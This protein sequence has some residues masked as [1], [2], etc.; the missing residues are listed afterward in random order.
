MPTRANTSPPTRCGRD[1][2]GNHHQARQFPLIM[3]PGGFAVDAKFMEVIRLLAL[4]HVPLL[5]PNTEYVAGRS[6][7]P[8]TGNC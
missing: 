1:H 2:A 4:D 7:A 3:L 6:L 5:K 8:N